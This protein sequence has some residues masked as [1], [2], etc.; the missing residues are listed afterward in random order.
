MTKPTRDMDRGELCN[1]AS[2][3]K[4]ELVMARFILENIDLALTGQEPSDFALSF[5]LVRKVWDAV[6]HEWSVP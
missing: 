4:N 1:L 2:E 6:N 3:L 5:P